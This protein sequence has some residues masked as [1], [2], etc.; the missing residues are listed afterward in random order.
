MKSVGHYR[1]VIGLAPH[2]SCQSSSWS[3]GESSHNILLGGGCQY[4]YS[5]HNICTEIYVLKSRLT[6]FSF[7]SMKVNVARDT[8]N[9]NTLVRGRTRA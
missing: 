8:L 3:L 5:K 2:F 4:V 9:A 1:S 6:G 7:S